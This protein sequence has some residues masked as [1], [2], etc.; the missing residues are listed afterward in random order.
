M[1]CKNFND[2]ALSIIGSAYDP[3]LLTICVVNAGGMP[4][5]QINPLG[6][7]DWAKAAYNLAMMSLAHGHDTVDFTTRRKLDPDDPLDGWRMFGRGLTIATPSLKTSH[8][9]WFTKEPGGAPIKQLGDGELL[10]GAI[11]VTQEGKGNHAVIEQARLLVPILTED[12]AE[13]SLM[14]V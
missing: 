1:I 14:T 5:V 13:T 3:T 8:E 4:V 11:G 2:I 12:A 9:P 6:E 10:I 7:P